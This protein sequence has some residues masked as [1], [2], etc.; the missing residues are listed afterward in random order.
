M[1]ASDLIEIIVENELEDCEIMI[2][3]P[4]ARDLH[5]FEDIPAEEND[6]EFNDKYIFIG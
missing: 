2:Q 6:V 4:R 3:N 5:G 1:R